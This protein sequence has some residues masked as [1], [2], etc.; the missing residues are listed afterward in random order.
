[1]WEGKN[2][3]LQTPPGSDSPRAS[4]LSLGREQSTLRSL[5]LTTFTSGKHQSITSVIEW[6]EL[7][8]TFKII[9]FQPHCRDT[10]H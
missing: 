6:G 7:K 3:F 5:F 8:G 1:M 2:E 10:F 4:A 9:W